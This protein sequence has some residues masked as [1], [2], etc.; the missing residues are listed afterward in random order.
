MRETKFKHGT[1]WV[2]VGDSLLPC[3]IWQVDDQSLV[4]STGSKLSVSGRCDEVWIEVL[5]D[6]F[7]LFVKEVLDANEAEIQSGG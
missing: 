6:P 3:N 1:R 4:S 2:L 7:V 5:E